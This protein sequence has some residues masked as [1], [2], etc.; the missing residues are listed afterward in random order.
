MNFLNNNKKLIMNG[1]KYFL[2][3]CKQSHIPKIKIKGVL[4]FDK[5][6]KKQHTSIYAFNKING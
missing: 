3:T 4:L 6:D 5:I 1:S 2:L